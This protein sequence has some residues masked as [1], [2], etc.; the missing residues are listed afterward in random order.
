MGSDRGGQVDG[1]DLIEGTGGWDLIEGD[2]WMNGGVQVDGWDLREG[3][4]T[5]EGGGGRGWGVDWKEWGRE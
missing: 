3:G 4:W 2:R 5:V 1:W